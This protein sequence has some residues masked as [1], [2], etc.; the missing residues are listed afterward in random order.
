MALPTA[1]GRGAS[2]ILTALSHLAL[3][4]ISA[5]FQLSTLAWEEE[6]TETEWWLEFDWWCACTVTT[7]TTGTTT[8]L[9]SQSASLYQGEHKTGRPEYNSIVWH[10]ILQGEKYVSKYQLSC[11][12][13][14][15][16]GCQN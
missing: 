10:N 13:A 6:M 4:D 1:G 9:D 7:G 16:I 11:N 14:K 8:L 5:W 2:G 3:L 12:L 15:G